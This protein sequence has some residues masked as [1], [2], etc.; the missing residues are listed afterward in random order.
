MSPNVQFHVV[1]EPVDVSVNDTGSGTVPTSGFALKSAAGGGTG[2][3]VAVT[4]GVTPEDENDPKNAV[5]I[6]YELVPS[7]NTISTLSGILLHV[8]EL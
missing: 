6:T 3:A 1:G 4:V 7:S 5:V 8:R 2:V